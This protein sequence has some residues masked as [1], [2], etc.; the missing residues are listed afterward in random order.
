MTVDLHHN[1]NA[2]LKIENINNDTTI[3][4]YHPTGALVRF[5]KD[6]TIT[7]YSP[8]KLIGESPDIELRGKVKISGN[9]EVT[10]TITAP[11]G[12]WHLP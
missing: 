1:K 7:A 8:K 12:A 4:I 10:G 5:D 11:N 2:G 6:G 9:L 3:N